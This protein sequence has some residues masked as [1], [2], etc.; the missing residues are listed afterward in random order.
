MRV[1][2]CF[3]ARRA[4]ESTSKALT[5]IAQLC[6]SRS[7]ALQVMIMLM[8]TFCRRSQIFQFFFVE[9]YRILPFPGF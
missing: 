1:S 3:S 8:V 4:E 5:C 2:A 9:T 7:V 6:S